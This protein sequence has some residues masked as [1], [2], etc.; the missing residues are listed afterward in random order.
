MLGPD[1]RASKAKRL[2]LVALFCAILAIGVWTARVQVKQDLASM[3]TSCYEKRL[4][5]TVP[6]RN[7]DLWR[8]LSGPEHARRGTATMFRIDSLALSLDMQV[9]TARLTVKRINGSTS[10][11]LVGVG[12]SIKGTIEVV[13]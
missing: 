4:G 2:A 11:T 13:Y 1:S 6:C 10:E 3:I 12:K 8:F 5:A 9:W 7:D